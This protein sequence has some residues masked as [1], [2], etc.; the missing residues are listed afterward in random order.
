MKSTSI[1]L[2]CGGLDSSISCIVPGIWCYQVSRILTYDMRQHIAYAQEAVTTCF[3]FL[4]ESGRKQS[5][6][7]A[8]ELKLSFYPSAGGLKNK[9][10]SFFVIF[11]KR[12]FLDTCCTA[13]QH[14]SNCEYALQ[15]AQK[16]ANIRV[17]YSVPMCVFFLHCT[18]YS[19][20]RASFL[21]L[22]T[23][24]HAG[25]PSVHHGAR[26]GPGRA[27]W[28]VLWAFKVETSGN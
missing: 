16:P 15:V 23:A 12:T 25:E 14:A 2:G 20:A 27:P 6:Q 22:P 24:G 18:L 21:A 4:K 28:R 11:S 8:W 26:L 10:W 7:K 13:V 3:R 9:T 17:Y 1:L 5:T 19:G